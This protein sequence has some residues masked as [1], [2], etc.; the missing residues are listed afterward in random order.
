MNSYGPVVIT[1]AS[2]TIGAALARRCLADGVAVNLLTRSGT[3]PRRLEPL[4]EDARVLRVDWDEPHALRELV[5]TLRPRTVF[6]LAGTRFAPPGPTLDEHIGSAVGVSARLVS[7]LGDYSATAVVYASSG[8]VYGDRVGAV[9]SVRVEPT[10]WLGATKAMAEELLAA[11][12]RMHGRSFV[13]LRLF[14]PFGPDEEPD[15]L[16]ASVVRAGLA[17]VTIEL[18]S[19]S[20]TRDY[21]FIDDVVDAFVRAARLRPAQPATFNIGSGRARTVRSVAEFILAQLGRPDLA[22]FGARP[23]RPGDIEAMEAE[24][25]WSA[26]ALGWTPRVTF[27]QGIERTIA[28]AQR[29]RSKNNRIAEPQGIST[30]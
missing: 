18:T 3:L 9:E 23:S 21:V 27:A 30:R 5:D 7:A 24:G 2:G 13:A 10:S 28:A 1:G 8:A 14:T 16:V 6:H 12:A 4:A 19:G 17:G 25:T 15:R 22:Q 29:A 26:A 20:Q 11:E